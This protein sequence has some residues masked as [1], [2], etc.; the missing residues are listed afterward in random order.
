MKKVTFLLIFLVSQLNLISQSGSIKGAVFENE[1]APV[2]FANVLLLNASDSAFIKGVISEQDGSFLFDQVNHGD[3][4]VKVSM[5]GYDDV[6]SPA[7]T[8][9]Q[10]E[11]QLEKVQLNAGVALDE[12]TVVT[13]KPFI[14]MQADKVIVNVANSSVN[15]GNT[16]LEVLQKSPG[17]DID[18]DN[19]IS[20]RGRQGV[21]VTINGKNQYM[22]GD[23]ISQLLENMPSENIEKIEIIMNPSARYDA[24]GNAGIINIVLKKNEN[25]GMNGSVNLS[26]R[27][28]RHF[29]NNQGV[30]LNYRSEKVNVYGSA[31]RWDWAGYQD[32]NLLRKI[33]TQEGL[34][35]FGQI[36]DM[37]FTSGGQDAK[38]GVDYSLSKNTDV[39]V[40]FKYNGNTKDNNTDNMTMVSGVNAP[41]FGLLNVL[42]TEDADRDQL[43]ANF[44]F[45]HKFDDKGTRLT[46]D[47]DWSN[48]T[49]DGLSRYDNFYKD[50]AGQEVLDPY[51][52]RNF[53]VTDI[54]IKAGKVDFNTKIKDINVEVGAKL[55]MVTTNN[56]TLFEHKDNGEWIN[57]VNR[58]NNFVYDE[59]VLAGYANASKAFGKVMVQAGLRVEHTESV[60]N[61]LTL[62]QEVKRSYT[63]L[64]P[65]LSISHSIKE[66]HNLSYSYSR[67]INRPN[68]RS[69][70]PFVDYLDEFTF[71]KGNPFL[72]PQ[73]TNA[74]GV[75]YSLGRSLFVSAN[76]SYTKDAITDV[77][78]QFSEANTTFQTTQNLDNQHSASLTISLP[79]VWSE[80]WTSRLSWT[81]FY[82]AFESPIPSGQL[83]NASWGS[84]V[85][86]GNNIQLPNKWNMEANLNYTTPLTWGLFEV[87][88][89]WGI[90][91]GVSKSILK[92]KGNL[93]LGVDDIF[94][95]RIERVN[96]IQDDIDLYVNSTRDTRR[97][98]IS[99]SYNFGN[100][101][102]K[103][104]KKRKTA[105]EEENSRIGGD[106][107]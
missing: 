67:R 91:L 78:E 105:T 86:L 17:I 36:S 93:K 39:G 83:S 61:S 87:R 21:L 23:E 106:N 20:L 35:T 5:I 49:S 82:N 18:Q 102:V 34:T 51:Y 44:N 48:Y 68:Y 97:A 80:K 100:A 32:L 1:N 54:D 41:G 107:N 66:K 46:A 52:L 40:L 94:K 74:F 10:N 63:D 95:T 84:N 59:E 85:Y 90:D 77:I 8:L 88:S 65:S 101:K 98:K 79:K 42:S 50:E 57:Q 31:S 14:E 58:S 64:F 12:V 37:K 7:F 70:N 47:F 6:S 89:K 99:F 30:N 56:N 13:K 11:L 27:Q 62:D 2:E 73:Y 33:P 38:I 26:A 55:S 24:E 103:A 15:S 81:N 96:V 28:G 3:Y 92:G 75:N 71:S 22:T 53:Q 60:G 43:S 104:A 16:A 45:S 4:F 76:Y 72:N 25:I 29:V 69:L 19:N 9:N